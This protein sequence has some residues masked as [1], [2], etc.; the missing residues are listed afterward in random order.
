MYICRTDQQHRTVERSAARKNRLFRASTKNGGTDALEHRLQWVAE[1]DAA[2][3]AVGRGI[4]T[5]ASCVGAAPNAAQ[6]I[7]AHTIS[8]HSA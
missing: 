2:K 5:P 3:S 6:A 7:N 8:D 4:A 1:I